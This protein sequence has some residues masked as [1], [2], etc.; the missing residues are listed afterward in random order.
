MHELAIGWPQVI[1]II[2]ASMSF[3]IT[4]IKD[5]EPRGNYSMWQSVFSLAIVLPLLWWGGFFTA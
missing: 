5:G 2:L 4:V 1:Y 3:G